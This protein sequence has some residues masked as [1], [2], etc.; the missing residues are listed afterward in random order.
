MGL[1]LGVVGVLG[2]PFADGESKKQDPSIA[3]RDF[4]AVKANSRP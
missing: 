3:E 4:M 2:V 1:R